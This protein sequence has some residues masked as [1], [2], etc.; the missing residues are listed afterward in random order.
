[1]LLHI[2][3]A[4]LSLTITAQAAPKETKQDLLI[5]LKPHAA[6][7]MQLFAQLEGTGAKV[8]QLSDQ[9][10]HVQGGRAV[11]STA[12]LMKNSNVEYVQPNYPIHLLEDYSIQDKLRLAAVQKM[13]ARQPQ[14]AEPKD[15]KYTDN[16]AIP[17]AP[18]QQTGADPLVGNQW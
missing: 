17:D 5:K 14:A 7:S 16:P 2:L 3:T 4:A 12:T 13:L 10:V 15:P 11:A 18:Q 6:Y 9:W 1:M 8:E